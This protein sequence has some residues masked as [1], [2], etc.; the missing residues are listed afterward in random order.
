MSINLKFIDLTS[1]LT[2]DSTY[3]EGLIN[4][5]KG[6][7]ALGAGDYISYDLPD[8][9]VTKQYEDLR[10]DT[11][12]TKADPIPSIFGNTLASLTK[13]YEASE[14]EPSPESI[15]NDNY[16]YHILCEILDPNGQLKET[17]TLPIEKT[18]DAW[19]VT[20][21]NDTIPKLLEKLG[22]G[23]S[24]I[25]LRVMES[26]YYKSSPRVIIPLEIRP[27]NWIH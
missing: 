22:P 20:I 16:V 9:N 5:H 13:V 3:V 19:V 21:D 26:E 2:I 14:L 27:A 7:I 23:L 12:V 18:L 11:Y 15:L 8:G 25:K 6:D 17:F 24:T 10:I 1:M 4:L